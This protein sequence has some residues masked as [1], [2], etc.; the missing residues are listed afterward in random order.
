MELMLTLTCVCVHACM[1]RQNDGDNA[2]LCACVH[3]CAGKTMELMLTLTFMR[4]SMVHQTP[5]HVDLTSVYVCMFMCYGFMLWPRSSL[6][7]CLVHINKNNGCFLRKKFCLCVY[8]D[9]YALGYGA[10][11]S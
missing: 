6:D 9:L 8:V 4:W 1:C 5:I 11:L 3:A 7:C 2:Y 10:P